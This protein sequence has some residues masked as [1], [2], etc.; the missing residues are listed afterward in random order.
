MAL[1]SVHLSDV[2]V[3]AKPELIK[4]KE[5]K[6]VTNIRVADNRMVRDRNGKK[7][8]VTYY[9]TLV[10]WGD[11]A[12]ACVNGLDMGS[13]VSAEGELISKARKPEDGNLHTQ[14]DVKVR[15][16]HWVRDGKFEEE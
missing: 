12:E 8:Q 7:N 1:N 4:T 3:V 11:Q 13:L 16:I 14:V 2:N 9:F 10:V 5:G 6:S 15:K